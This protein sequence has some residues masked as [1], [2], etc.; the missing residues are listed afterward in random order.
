MSIKYML[1]ISQGFAYRPVS[2]VAAWGASEN[3]TSLRREQPLIPGTVCKAGGN[4]FIRVFCVYSS[5][6]RT[7]SGMTAD[8]SRLFARSEFTAQVDLH[9]PFGLI[10]VQT[11]A[12]QVEKFG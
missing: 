4:A 2:A 6:M 11:T 9:Q 5:G 12:Q 10:R 3:C 7:C 8:L 1:F